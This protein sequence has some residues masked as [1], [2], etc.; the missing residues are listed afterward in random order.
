MLLLE[1]PK[2]RPMVVRLGVSGV[3]SAALIVTE[4]CVCVVVGVE[5]CWRW[6]RRVVGGGGVAGVVVRE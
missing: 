2:V 3:A 6:W 5:R 4:V 1:L